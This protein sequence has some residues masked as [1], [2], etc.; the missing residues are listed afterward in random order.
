MLKKIFKKVFLF[1]YILF[2]TFFDSIRLNSKEKIL[3][4][5]LGSN[6]GQSYKWFSKFYRNKNIFY[7]LFEPNPHCFNELYNFKGK[8]VFI[9][10]CAVGTKDGVVKF[11]G[12]AK[13]EGGNKSQGGS[14]I[15]DHNSVYYKSNKN[16]AIEVKIIDFVKFLKNKINKFDKIFLKIDIEGAEVELLEHIIESD[17]TFYIDTIY[18]E[19]HSQYRDKKT[20]L[21]VKEREN[22]IKLYLKHKTNVRLRAWQ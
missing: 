10:N 2:F 12:L 11:Y 22:K 19:F 14:I 16:K 5:D 7:E 18:I 17:L 4:L 1:L 15:K 13:D 3:F 9:H 6:I 21:S 20:L 8:N